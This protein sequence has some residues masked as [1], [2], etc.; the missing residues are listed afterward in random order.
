MP[1]TLMQKAAVQKQKHVVNLTDLDRHLTGHLG[2]VGMFSARWSHLD[3]H[4]FYNNA[5][6]H[7]HIYKIIPAPL[8][9]Y[10]S[11]IK[12]SATG[13]TLQNALDYHLAK[14]H[15]NLVMV[16][17]ISQMIKL[18]YHIPAAKKYKTSTTFRFTG[19]VS[20]FDLDNLK[21]LA[22]KPADV[23]LNYDCVS[24]LGSQYSQ[25]VA[26]DQMSPKF[27]HKIISKFHVFEQEYENLSIYTLL[28]TQLD[29]AQKHYFDLFKQTVT[30][31]ISLPN[32]LPSSIDI[33]K[34][35][36]SMRVAQY[37]LYSLDTYKQEDKI[38]DYNDFIQKMIKKYPKHKDD[39]HK[40]VISNSLLMLMTSV[41]ELKP[42]SASRLTKPI[43]YQDFMTKIGSKH[44]YTR[45]QLNFI[46][47]NSRNIVAMAGAGTGKST[48]L[49]G[50]IKYLKASGID[51]S[52]ILVLSFTNAAANNITQ[53]FPGVKSYTI[54]SVINNVYK[55]FFNQQLSTADTLINSLRMVTNPKS[56]A[57][58]RNKLI[59][60]LSDISS[61]R[62]FKGMDYD[63]YNYRILSLLYEDPAAV[64]KE[65]DIV[66]QTTLELQQSIL[67]FTLSMVN[68]LPQA[69]RDVD[70]ILVDEAQDTSL[71][72][73]IFLTRM[74]TKINADI[75][76]IGDANQTLYEFR[77]AY[78]KSLN[79]IADA[80]QT[81]HYI[82]DVNHRSNDYILSLA[83]E[84][85]K[86]L[87]TNQKAN[88]Q[89][90]SSHLGSLTEDEYKKHVQVHDN[91]QNPSNL[92]ATRGTQLAAECLTNYMKTAKDLT[93]YITDAYF[94]NEQVAFLAISRD[95]VRAFDKILSDTFGEDKVQVLTPL[96]Q[97][98]SDQLS[99][100]LNEFSNKGMWKKLPQDAHGA[101]DFIKQ[102]I[103]SIIHSHSKYNV[104]K[105]IIDALNFAT[106]SV[107]Y[108]SPYSS[109]RLLLTQAL[110]HC[111]IRHNA[112]TT[113]LKHEDKIDMTKP[114]IVSTIH[115]AK[116]LEFPHVVLSFMENKHSGSQ[117]SLRALG[118]GLT[119]AKNDE[120]IINS[121]TTA[122]Y[123]TRVVDITDLGLI[124]HPISSANLRAIQK[125]KD[126][127]AHTK[128]ASHLN[129]NG[130][131][132]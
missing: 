114:F 99:R 24:G 65:L 93:K 67:Y 126:E 28:T 124:D 123:A 22:I 25:T 95:E 33:Y 118:V 47:S 32:V 131:N 4:Q 55:T 84:V 83:N 34:L 97:P 132:H 11:D 108:S 18:T 59:D 117:S 81:A 42:K 86:V 92:I 51:P 10:D 89:L 79:I 45:E 71:F 27:S 31:A 6:D 30:D 40:L 8:A 2:K 120:Y 58:V 87:S 76:F 129:V 77:N 56:D 122:R 48:A 14:R 21:K 12:T 37:I 9:T 88:M 78:A 23:S 119:R 39:L 5:K 80:P 53:R 20:F 110:E 104:P 1:K 111:E 61:N 60:A 7:D 94:K 49:G 62:R 106:S 36:N 113:T 44:T 125:I 105:W 38:T 66:G 35:S 90:S 13:L 107:L 109:W 82:F 116:G 91:A 74:S 19:T 85:L 73:L 100:A 115:S 96:T 26:Y 29:V 128:S 46:T 15:K 16:P 43:S 41:D 57:H 127:Q 130:L 102:G 54:A 3:E 64:V 70:F 69:F 75:N 103:Y 17:L 121:Y 98:W 63:D 68:K 50:R 112:V 72:E 101:Q 52:R